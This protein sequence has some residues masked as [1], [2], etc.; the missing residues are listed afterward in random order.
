MI[1][2]VRCGRSCKRADVKTVD[3]EPVCVPCLYGDV[4]P[5]VMYPIG[6][7]VNDRQRRAR[8][9][10]TRSPTDSKISEI[11][12][13][14]G[15][16]SLMGGLADE[17]HLV[18]VWQLHQSR[19]VETVFSRGWDHKKV[20]P[21]ASRTPDRLTPIAITEVELVGVEGT[22]LRVRGLDAINGTPVLDIKMS[23]GSKRRG[24]EGKGSSP[25]SPKVPP[26]VPPS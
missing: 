12:L 13:N 7:V 25:C 22:V 16:A 18:I 17:K 26:K 21:F 2:C 14:P 8:G 15:L 6:T 3:G 24:R 20:G 9:F 10:G 4:K 19:G 23:I 5:V 11:R 1:S